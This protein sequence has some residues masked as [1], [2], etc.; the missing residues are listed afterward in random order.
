[1]TKLKSSKVTFKDPIPYGD[2][3]LKE[4]TLRPPTAGDL[5]G[6]NIDGIGSM[7]VEELMTLVPRISTPAVTAAQLNELSAR[8]V[9]KLF[10]SVQPFFIPE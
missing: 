1:M 9:T 7:R 6:V 10:H 8:D 3:P 4:I 2:N 5:R